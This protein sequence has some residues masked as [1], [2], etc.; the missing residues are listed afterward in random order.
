GHF[1]TRNVIPSP[2]ETIGATVRLPEEKNPRDDRNRVSSSP[3]RPFSLYGIGTIGQEKVVTY[4]AIGLTSLGVNP[5]LLFTSSFM[6]QTRCLSDQCTWSWGHSL[7]FDLEKS[8][9]SR[10]AV[11]LVK[12]EPGPVDNRRILSKIILSPRRCR[13][14]GIIEQRLCDVPVCPDVGQE[15]WPPWFPDETGVRREESP[16][17]R[18]LEESPEKKRLGWWR[19]EIGVERKEGPRTP[20]ALENRNQWFK[21]MSERPSEKGL[22]SRDID[23]RNT[24]WRKTWT[25]LLHLW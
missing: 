10:L 11:I 15:S 18:E 19:I 6:T 12:G 16:R 1:L 4:S 13:E 24:P 7:L 2:S 3:L 22:S 9:K 14:N 17:W 23:S 5:A 21:E 20:V 8:T 25:L